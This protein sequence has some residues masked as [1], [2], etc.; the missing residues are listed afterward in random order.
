MGIVE[1]VIRILKKCLLIKALRNS[2]NE[3]DS[4]KDGIFQKYF[5]ME[6]Y[7]NTLAVPVSWLFEENILTK[8]NYDKLS[9]KGNINVLRR[10]CLNTPALVAYDSLPERFKKTVVVKLNNKNPYDVVKTNLIESYIQY[11]AKLTD[12]FETYKLGD[13]RNLS[14]VAAIGGWLQSIGKEQNAERIKAIACRASGYEHFNQIPKNRLISLYH[15]FV[16]MKND[17]AKIEEL[18]MEMFTAN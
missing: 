16:K 12:F 18:T 11:N 8:P 13:G 3:G 4:R 5:I 7:N 9:R 1:Q 2:R 10:G 15:G 14:K 17:M 6:L